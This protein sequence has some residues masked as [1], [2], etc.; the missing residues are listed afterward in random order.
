MFDFQ[1]DRSYEKR[2]EH[3]RPVQGGP[4]EIAYAD[5]REYRAQDHRH[6][7]RQ[8]HQHLGSGRPFAGGDKRRGDRANRH[9]RRQQRQLLHG[10]KTRDFKIR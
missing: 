8:S 5:R 10:R 9:L 2:H 3:S 4:L 1:Q 7:R 6:V